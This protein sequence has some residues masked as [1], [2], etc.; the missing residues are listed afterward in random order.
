MTPTASTNSRSASL[1]EAVASIRSG[2]TVA[3]GGAYFYRHPMAL[4]RAIIRAGVKDLTLVVSLSSIE[5]DLLI[6]AGAVKKI[7]FGF[8]S[9]DVLGLAPSFRKALESGAVEP[10]EYGDLPLMRSLEASTRELP[11]MIARS[12]TGTDLLRHHPAQSFLAETG[13]TLLQLPPIR[14]DVFLIHAQWSDTLG[15]LIIEGESYDI[16]MAKA[17]KSV[18]ATVERVVGHR[19]LSRLG[20]STIP[21][22]TVKAL[23][24]LPSEPT[25]ARAIPSTFTT[26]GI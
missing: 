19:E 9:F 24:E 4:V 18:I 25:R 21:N 5:S 11:Y 20:K 6:A 15:N 12:L 7:I 3:I 22:Y 26:C 16:E 17:S 10:M 2:D 13:E 8:V 1:E 14:P 23:V